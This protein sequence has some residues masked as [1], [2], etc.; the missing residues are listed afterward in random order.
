MGDEVD[1]NTFLKHVSDKTIDE[2]PEALNN[3]T[4]QQV[5]EDEVYTANGEL[6]GVWRYLLIDPATG[7]E[8]EYKLTEMSTLMNN[9]TSNVHD[10]SLNNLAADG[11][12][13]INGSILTQ[14]V[15]EVKGMLSQTVIYT[16][17]ANKTKIGDLSVTELLV[18]FEAVLSMPT[19]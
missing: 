10:A 1:G 3:L 14:D 15:K 7:T 6:N 11:I 9:M 13:E 18:Y 2:L 12:I 4:I 5:F 8:K 19:K 16:P 17:P